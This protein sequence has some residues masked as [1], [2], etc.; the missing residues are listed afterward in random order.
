MG[1]WWIPQATPDT[2]Q[3]LKSR[4]HFTTTLVV[5]GGPGGV[6]VSWVM[7]RGAVW[8][9]LWPQSREEALGRFP[10]CPAASQADPDPK[11]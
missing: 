1:Q 3:G 9:F 11:D 5:P 2:Q 8:S 7:E 4:W 10:M 6:A